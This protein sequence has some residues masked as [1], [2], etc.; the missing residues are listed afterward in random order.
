MII[1]SYILQN[2]RE[3]RIRWCAWHIVSAQKPLATIIT[4]LKIIHC[5]LF[6]VTDSE[7]H[8]GQLG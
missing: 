4:S 6:L 2:R 3:E 7:S 5:D 8:W 1:L